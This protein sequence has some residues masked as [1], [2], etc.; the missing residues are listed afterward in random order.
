RARARGTNNFIL[1]DVT[2]MDQAQL[3]E[4]IYRERRVELAMEQNR[5]FDL[6]RWGRIAEVMDPLF[7]NFDGNKHTLLPIPQSEI[8]LSGGLILQNP[9]Y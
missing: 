2:T 3:R 5:W 4:I 9:N 8:D 6:A 1:P 7:P